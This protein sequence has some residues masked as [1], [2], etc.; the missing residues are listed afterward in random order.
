MRALN[1]IEDEAVPARG[2]WALGVWREPGIFVFFTPWV[3]GL[4][5]AGLAAAAVYH[6][7]KKRSLSNRPRGVAQPPGQSR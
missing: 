6:V 5:L 1:T 4:M 3:M 2:W 7:R